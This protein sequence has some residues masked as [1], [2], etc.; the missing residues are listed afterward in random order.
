MKPL[1]RQREHL[2]RA[3]GESSEGGLEVPLGGYARG[4]RA[5]IMEAL[6]G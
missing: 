4:V 6:G 2:E 3:S 1:G 5:V